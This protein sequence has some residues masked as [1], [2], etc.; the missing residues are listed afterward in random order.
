ML[1]FASLR[2]STTP[3][4]RIAIGTDNFRFIRENHACYIDEVLSRI[5]PEEPALTG[6]VRE[7]Q[8]RYE[9]AAQAFERA[10]NR[11]SALKNWRNAGRWAEALRL[12]QGQ[13]KDDLGW[14][15]SLKSVI[16]ARPY[17][18]AKRMTEAEQKALR[19]LVK[20]LR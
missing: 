7:Q 6:R 10:G 20:L 15:V 14:L 1:S 9:Q 19:E 17:G 8:E 12:A 13:A 16:A 18:Q 2:R 5:E 3:P 4:L 11:E